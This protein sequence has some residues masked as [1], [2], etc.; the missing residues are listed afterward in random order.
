MFTYGDLIFSGISFTKSV[1]D[2]SKSLREKSLELLGGKQQIS[3]KKAVYLAKYMHRVYHVR[4]KC[5]KVNFVKHK[6]DW[7]DQVFTE[8]DLECIKP[9]KTS[10]TPVRKPF[11][12]LSNRQK[13][14][15]SK[16]FGES[17]ERDVLEYHVMHDVHLV[18]MVQ[19]AGH[20]KCHRYDDSDIEEALFRKAVQECS[21]EQWQNEIDYF[22]EEASYKTLYRY[23]RR[24][25]IPEYTYEKGVIRVKLQDMLKL[26]LARLINSPDSKILNDLQSEDLSEISVAVK[27]G[28]D[29]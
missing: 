26:T 22:D 16:Q 23:E 20:V 19:A 10:K 15:R 1:V 24:H 9:P 8:D 17:C 4:Y 2:Y 27:W 5:H 12:D 21:R 3:E 13:Q 18:K 28:A 29:G 14:R 11:K 6:S 25:I 7:L